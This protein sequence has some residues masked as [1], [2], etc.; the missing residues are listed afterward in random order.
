MVEPGMPEQEWRKSQSSGMECVEIARID[1]NVHIRNSR[2]PSDTQL[3]FSPAE[4]RNF[5]F[6]VKK[7]EFE[8]ASIP[9]I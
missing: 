2:S 7:G 5:L 3:H 9:A 4:F 8:P 6:G 1:G